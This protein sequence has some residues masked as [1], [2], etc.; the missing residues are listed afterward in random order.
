MDNTEKRL[1]EWL[2]EDNQLGIDIWHKKY[3]H[4]DES[5]DEWLDRVSAG[6]EDIKE[7]I[8]AKR[9]LFGGRI[10]ANRGLHKEGVKVTY[11]NCYVLPAPEDNIESIYDTASKLA[12]TFSYGGG[13]GIDISKLAP[14]GARVN[15]TAKETSGAVSFMDLYGMTTGLIGQN[16]RRGA[17]M[18]S[19]DCHHPDLEEFI[20]LKSDLDKVTTAN[21]SIRM[22]DDFMR[23]VEYGKDV[24]LFYNRPEVGQTIEKTV[25]AKE[26]FNEIAFQ[27]WDMG[28]PGVLFW[29]NIRNWNLLSND[30]NFEYAGTNPCAEEPLPAGGSCLLGSINLSEFVCNPYTEKPEFDMATYRTTIRRAVRALNDVLDEG[31]PL[32][33]LQIQR[34]TVRDWRQIGL[35]V[36]GIAD[37]LV[38]MGLDYG[39][40]KARKFCVIIAKALASTAIS[41]SNRLARKFGAYPKY[42]NKVFDTPYIEHIYNE[43]D[44]KLLAIMGLRNSQLLTIAPTGTLSTMLGVSGGI[45]PFFATEWER[46]TKSLHGEDVV[47]KE[48]PRTIE[49]L[50]KTQDTDIIP[51]YVVTSGDIK[52]I[53]RIKMQAV[54]Q[55]YIDAS[56]SSTIN[57]PNDTTPEEVEEIY[58]QA[59]KHGL[60]GVTV[61]RDGCRRVA[62]LNAP[63]KDEDGQLNDENIKTEL[64][65]LNNQLRRGDILD[66]SDDLLS[67]KRTLIN[68]C[69]KMYL[70]LDFDEMTGEPLET[71]IECGSGG[72]CERN[73][74]FISRL[75][76]VALRGGIPIEAIIDQAMSVK[77]CKAYCDR[78]KL[79]HDTSRGTSCPQSIGY[80]MEELYHKIQDRCFAD[81]GGY[82]VEVPIDIEEIDD[83]TEISNDLD[84]QN[85]VCPECGEQLFMEGGCV[86]CKSCG[87]SRCD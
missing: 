16:G 13:V 69:G 32:H 34:D 10:L 18:I 65:D 77:P 86:I 80:A 76:S 31:L 49:E 24:T 75:I 73:L 45:E 15:N 54:W 20:K 67:A 62:I 72:G 83:E 29:D 23:A 11:S 51:N 35:G 37:M 82:D 38:K 9:F 63:T 5:F 8:E 58:M 50:L 79:K 57:L 33:P 4:D 25:N 61:F 19:M 40:E 81:D 42:T 60:K 87:W 66:V 1:Q 55:R 39:S 46:T 64:A 53:D 68:G 78:T 7:E 48:H 56:I 43:E 3:Q 70:H 26:I 17:L 14:K 71:W 21:I 84:F 44:R 47:Y 36:F 6:D 85:P 41:E 27:N 74:T 22:D 52:P 28:E 12:R 2:G 59:W 30:D